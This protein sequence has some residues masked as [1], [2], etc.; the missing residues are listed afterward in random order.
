MLTSSNLGHACLPY[1][2]R[3]KTMTAMNS[4]PGYLARARR[5]VE[6]II[7]PHACDVDR[8]QYPRTAM[9]SLGAA[10]LLGLT[11][12][13]DVGGAG[14]GLRAAAEV[15]EFVGGACGSTGMV[16][17]MHYCGAAVIERHG[18]RAVRAAIAAGEHITTLA[19]SEAGSRSHFWAPVST[20]R[21][22][23]G[24]KIRLDAEKSWSTSAG[25]AD[26]YVWSSQPVAAQELSTL[27]L[28]PASA[29]G[30]SVPRPFDGLGLRGNSSAPI[31]ADNVLVDASAMLG[32]DGGGLDIMMTTV[33]PHFQVLS[34]ACYVGLV[35]AAVTGAIAHASRAR[36]AHIDQTLAD[37]PTIRAF[38][39]RCIVKRDMA[40]ALLADTLAALESSRPDAL[41]RVL[42]VKAAAAEVATEVTELAMR[43]CGGAAF[44]KE[45]GVERHFRDA[46]AATVMSPTTDL[47]YDFIGKHACGLPLL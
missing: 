23:A 18:P 28:V 32:L 34:A 42:E 9:R 24:A 13:E 41:L 20:A 31:R 8:G 33:L 26:S 29:P 21:A 4:D 27:W 11:S 45:V 39:A 37:L 12:A 36:F 44:R 14:L 15:V 40:R 30:L 3:H 22:V 7:A 43:I 38:V 19:F 6:E 35:D 46:H 10:G 16:L 1:P 47:L 5:I 2:P 17:C 25:Q